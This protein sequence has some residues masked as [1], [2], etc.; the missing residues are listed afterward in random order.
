MR[1]ATAIFSTVAAALV[2]AGTLYADVI[3]LKN[4]GE[5]RG[6]IIEQDNESV[7]IEVPDG[8]I[9][10]KR[11]EILKIIQE[12]EGAYLL[13]Q[14]DDL[15]YLGAFEGAIK[16]YR[17]ALAL[18]PD[19]A[20]L[21]ARLQRATAALLKKWINRRDLT[22]ALETKK[23]LDTL[24]EPGE[25]AKEASRMLAEYMEK[26]KQLQ[27]DGLKA[28][29]EGRA[30]DA[31][32]MLENA[33]DMAPGERAK[34]FPLLSEAHVK[35][36]DGY[37]NKHDYASAA[38]HYDMGVQYSGEAAIRVEA[39]W[40]FAKVKVATGLLSNGDFTA[41]RRELEPIYGAIPD[42]P[43]ILFA[44]GDTYFAEKLFDKA[45][46]F[47][48]KALGESAANAPAEPEDLREFAR[49]T[50][51]SKNIGTD[52]PDEERKKLA[53]VDGD[54]W[55]TR[56]TPHFNIKHKND[57]AA[58]RLA[59]FAE[60]HTGRLLAYFDAAGSFTTWEK[61]C[62]VELHPD[63]EA[64]KK[65]DVAPEWSGGLSIV[66]RKGGKLVDFRILLFQEANHLFIVMLPHELAH[67]VF[68]MATGF[69]KNVPLWLGEGVAVWFEPDFRHGYYR[70]ILAM[71]LDRDRLIPLK[72][73]FAMKGYPEENRD[74]Y[75]AECY[76]L[77]EM[78]IGRGGTAKI[79]EFSK[80]ISVSGASV[81]KALKD[82]YGF[83][84]MDALNDFYLD[85]IRKGAGQWGF[86]RK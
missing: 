34:L 66:E 55:K 70:R 76:F 65:T 80:K 37:F 20:V 10:L 64:Y 57:Y 1:Y 81:E 11:S 17:K 21:K 61:K 24:G 2:L 35:C 23:E 6:K 69:D 3:Q 68:H 30:A 67:I 78:L 85:Q 47:Y 86:Q 79:L 74:L 44:M 75:Y 50:V 31:A 43:Y 19:D 29:S 15:L 48:R 77:A 33:L 27:T 54:E 36:A 46:G 53:A 83:E 59:E 25:S 8:E 63:R 39:P 26:Y 73:L 14:G 82:L 45:A 5:L 7:T 12:K 18:S 4:G 22:L 13:R 16:F 56:E 51:F 38:K 60:Y 49:R 52:S 32:A 71:E 72:E 58:K 62:T 84:N 28:L 40:I 9:T 41:A 42:N